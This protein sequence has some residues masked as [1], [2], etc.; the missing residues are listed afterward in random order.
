MRHLRR[1]GVGRRGAH[2][3]Q[4][5]QEGRTRAHHLQ[6]PLRL[7]QQHHLDRFHRHGLRPRAHR[8]PVYERLVG[9]H[10]EH[11]PLHRGERRPAKTLRP[12]QRP[13][14]TSRPTVGRSGRRR[15]VL[16]L[17]QFRL[18]RLFLQPR[19]FAAGA[20]PLALGRNRQGDLLRQ[21]PL[22]PAVRHVQH[23]Q[24]QVHRLRFPHQGLGPD[25]PVAE[26]LEQHQ[27]RHFG[28]Q[29]R[30][31]LRLRGNDQRPAIEH[32]RRI[33]PLQPRRLDRP[34]R[35]PAGQELPDRRRPRR[36]DDRRPF[37]EL[38]GEPL[39]DAFEPVRHHD[40]QKARPH[41]GL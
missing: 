28:L 5:R 10:D 6:R 9:R 4:G 33:P 19:A 8:Q 37:E 18:V 12:P 23:Q 22:L 24:G 41:G 39:P 38:E 26:I 30:R 20:Q 16:L 7:G 36:A 21:R 25:D 14:G 27:L 1:Q 35:Q 3:H 11:L 17:R 29:I 40:R 2:H 34:V 15:Q 31:T 13:H 32:L